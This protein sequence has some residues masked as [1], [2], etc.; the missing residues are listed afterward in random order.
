M[1]IRPKLNWLRTLFVWHGSVLPQLLPR[2]TLIF[3]LSIAAIVMHDHM[4]HYPIGLGT[5]PFA[6]VGIALAVFLGLP[7]PRR[8]KTRS[9]W[10]RTTWRWMRY[11]NPWRARYT[12]WQPT[13]ASSVHPWCQPACRRAPMWSREAATLRA[14]SSIAHRPAAVASCS[15]IRNF[16][17]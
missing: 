16:L 10:T 14:N 8:S 1:I 5:P 7:A 9:A 11:A 17:D 15:A 3:L 4:R 6:L 12:T 2:L 13:P